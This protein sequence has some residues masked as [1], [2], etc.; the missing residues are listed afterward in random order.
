MSIAVACRMVESAHPPLL[1][2]VDDDVRSARILAQLLRE[3]GFQVE[4]ATDGASAIGRLA[5]SPIPDTLITDFRMPLAGGEE[6]ARYARS[7]CA[8]MPIFVVTGYPELVADLS[9]KFE[10]ALVVFSKPLPYNDF[11]RELK[12]P[13]MS[14]ESSEDK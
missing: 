3:D 10:P 2:I 9:A 11:A 12:R 5:R 1:L 4:I 7:R 6:V 13:F 14:V 8:N